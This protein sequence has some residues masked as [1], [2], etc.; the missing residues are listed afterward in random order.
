MLAGEAWEQEQDPA[1]HKVE[2][3]KDKEVE[4]GLKQ[5]KPQSLSPRDILP[6]ATLWSAKD[7]MTIPS[8]VLY[9]GSHI[10]V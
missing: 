6:L 4:A 10:Q 5:T 7:S 9:G 3:E 2:K 1:V 8:S